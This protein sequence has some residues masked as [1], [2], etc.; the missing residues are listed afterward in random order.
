MKPAFLHNSTSGLKAR[1]VGRRHWLLYSPVLSHLPLRVPC[2]L[3]S[4]SLSFCNPLPLLRAP[5]RARGSRGGDELYSHIF[6]TLCILPSMIWKLLSSYVYHSRSE[7]VPSPPASP[8][9]TLASP[10]PLPKEKDHTG[11]VFFPRKPC[12]HPLD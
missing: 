7:V 1:L 11:M 12:S 5:K 4:P 3:F 2:L 8:S 10:A 9:S 6:M